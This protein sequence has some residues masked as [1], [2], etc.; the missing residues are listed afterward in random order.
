[1]RNRGVSFAQLAA[2]AEGWSAEHHPKDIGRVK[3]RMRV[4]VAEFGD[5]TAE[6]IK[7]LDEHWLS[8]QQD[9]ATATKNRYRALMSL[10]Y[11]Q[12]RFRGPP[13]SKVMD[14]G[15]PMGRKFPV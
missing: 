1:M 6:G 15:L 10:V 4:L 11:R 7:P 12:F 5:R 3:S 14:P 2:G 13:T 8:S 9:W